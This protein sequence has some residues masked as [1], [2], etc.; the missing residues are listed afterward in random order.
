VGGLLALIPLFFW[1]HWHFSGSLPPWL[2]VLFV[3]VSP[4]YLLYIRQCR[5]YPLVMLFTVILLA[6]YAHPKATRRAAIV[7]S[8]SGGVAAILLMLTNYLNA[9]AIAGFLPLLLFL[10]RYRHRNQYLFLGSVY[11]AF[12]FMGL[13]ILLTANP[14]AHAVTVEG[15]IKGIAR[16]G[17]LVWFHIKDLGSFEF[18]PLLVPFV[19]L[20]CFVFKSLGAG[21]ALA[22]EGMLIILGMIFYIGVTI[23]FS[24][25]PILGGWPFA[26]M[27]Y[28]VPLIFIGAA[29]TACAVYT[30]WQCGKPL[31][32]V[33]AVSIAI[34]V[35]TTN[36][37]SL[38]FMGNQPLTSTLYRYVHENLNYY[39]TGTESLITYLRQM[40]QGKVVAIV[41][42]HMIYSAQFYAPEQHYCCQLSPDHPLRKDLRAQLPD[43]IFT[44]R[45]RPDYILVGGST[46]PIM[47]LAYFENIFGIGWYQIRE[48]LTDDWRDMSR[49]EIAWHSFGPPDQDR[50]GKPQRGFVVLERVK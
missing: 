26:D 38:G 11:A 18:F 23:V 25:Q 50:F 41:P 42:D 32:K 37:L 12:L 7:T 28:V 2:P 39:K 48:V 6:F 46:P 5:Y 47:V 15:E 21:K 14:F 22:G 34:L 24:P 30:L 8:L 4:A 36:V 27:R 1:V 44:G 31:W 45:I 40:P 49:P 29:V 16:F 10:P 20:S 19:L 3:A 43:Y 17:V 33:F 9:V 35:L 13:Y